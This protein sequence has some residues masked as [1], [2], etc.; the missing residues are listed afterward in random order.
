[1]ALMLVLLEVALTGA[2]MVE[3]L[4][5]DEA[6]MKDALTEVLSEHRWGSL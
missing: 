6:E 2:M 5:E 4:D 1:M 3:N